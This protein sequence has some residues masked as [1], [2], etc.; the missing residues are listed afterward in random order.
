MPTNKL[1]DANDEAGDKIALTALAL[2]VTSAFMIPPNEDQ[3]F[4]PLA[5]V[6]VRISEPFKEIGKTLRANLDG[7]L[8]AVSIPY[9]LANRSTVN[10]HWQRIYSSARILSLLL[11]ATPEETPD[12]LESRRERDA[13]ANAK[14]KMDEF[15]G[16]TAGK[17]ILVR[18]TLDFLYRLCSDQ[19]LAEAA[20]ELILQGSVLC[21][22]AF[23][24]LA[25]DSFAMHLNVH[26]ART[27]ALLDDPVAKRR[28]ELSKVSLETLAAHNFDLSG[29]MG[30]ML[31]DQQ[32]LSDV[33]SVKAVFQALFPSSDELRDALND[34]DLRLL[35]LRRNLIVH[36]RGII[37]GKYAAS[38]NCSQHVG[39]R[40]KIKPDEL[41]AHLRTTIKTAACILDAMME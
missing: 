33:Y 3:I 30:T 7:L 8:S 5:E 13:L 40:L 36:R 9:T 23:E 6:V 25:R 41:Q 20:N 28:F 11:E 14:P 1:P 21:W 10:A 32:D 27:L 17:D 22:G 16:S 18:D 39:Q 37:D 12:A 24:V 15:L 35:S 38:A 31:A 34:S 29:R 19:S 4:K 2:H 26:P